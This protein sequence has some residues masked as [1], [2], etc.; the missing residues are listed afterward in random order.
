M[1]DKGIPTT[2]LLA[3][4][5]VAKFADHLPPYRQEKV[6]GRAGLA[7]SLSTLAQWVGQTGVQRQPLVDA[8]REAVLSTSGHQTLERMLEALYLLSQVVPLR[9][10]LS[11]AEP[12]RRLGPSG[13]HPSH[14]RASACAHRL[15]GNAP[16]P[17]NL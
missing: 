16:L 1:I 7:I 9:G 4:V 6:F 14:L 3:H 11:R 15:L 12:P 17:V 2:G 10:R 8:L 13:I 5:M